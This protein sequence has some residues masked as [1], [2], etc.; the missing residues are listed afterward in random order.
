MSTAADV[1]V[2]LRQAPLG[3]TVAWPKVATG[4]IARSEIKFVLLIAA[5]VGALTSLPYAIGWRLDARETVFTGVL[6]HDT[7]SNNYLAYANQAASGSWLFHNPMTGEPHRAVF[8]NLEWLVIGRIAASLHISLPATTSL[9]R[10]LCIGLMSLGIYWLSTFVLRDT[11][12]R[13]AAVVAIMTGGGFGW[14]AAVHLFHVRLDSSYFLDLSNANLFPFYWALKVPHFLVSE[15]FVVFGLCCFLRGE[16]RGLTR[17][18][19]AAG[20]C[21][22]AA[23]GCRPY[24]MLYLMAATALY[25]VFSCARSRAIRGVTLIRTLP[26][27]MCFPL[28]I[29]YYWIFKVHPVFRWWSL[30]GRPAPAPWIL[31]LGFGLPFLLLVTAAS[32]LR[33]RHLDQSA[34]FL[35]SGLITAVCLAYLHHFL[36]FAFQFATNILAPTVMLALI[37]WETTLSRLKQR[38]G[39]RAL[40]AGILVINSFTSIA[41]TGQVVLLTRRGDFRLDAKLVEAYSWINS[42]SASSDLVLAD[43]ENSNHIPQYSHNN[44]FCGYA[45]AVNFPE[46]LKAMDQFFSPGVSNSFRQE[47]VSRNAVHFLFVTMAEQQSLGLSNAPF[48]REVFRNRRAVIFEA[49]AVN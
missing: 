7:D 34:S 44:V 10:L 30:P 42:H 17:D 18:Y 45:N 23:G 13:R 21:Y 26:L 36:H 43:Y 8:F 47:L 39:G 19:I 12:V 35:L 33:S 11:L 49:R 38:A 37:S 6:A 31:A 25:L 16:Q 22:L 20:A 2:R 14:L 41:L 5:A 40:I 28:L 46:K 9:L 1:N 27:L 3:S 32:R 15:T 4:V 48:L 29:Y 24:D